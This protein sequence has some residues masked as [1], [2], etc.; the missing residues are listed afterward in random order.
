MIAYYPANQLFLGGFSCYMDEKLK[1][2]NDTQRSAQN[3]KVEENKPVL[4]LNSPS[5]YVYVY[6]YATALWVLLFS[7][8]HI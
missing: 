6:V 3:Q 1:V 4:E 2:P 8:V 5:K 7:K